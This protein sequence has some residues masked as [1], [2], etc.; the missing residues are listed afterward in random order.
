MYARFIVPPNPFLFGPHHGRL[1]HELR[2]PVRAGQWALSLGSGATKPGARVVN[3][4]LQASAGVQVRGDGGRLPFRNGPSTF[5]WPAEY[6]SMSGPQRP[7][8]LR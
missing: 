5:C 7:A 6:S 3:L 1:A 8:E 4:D 2:D